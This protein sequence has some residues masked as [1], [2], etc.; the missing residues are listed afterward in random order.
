MDELQS[1]LT[2][3]LL[4]PF[5]LQ[6]L[7]RSSWFPV[8]TMETSKLNAIVASIIAVAGGV[9]IAFTYNAQSGVLTVT[10]LTLASIWNAL[11]HSILQF[12]MQHTVYRV[13]IAPPL[14]GPTQAAQREQPPKA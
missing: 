13:A 4:V 14:P 9:G 5:I 2:L 8:L 10:G 7:K 1:Q 11:Q 6:W 12:M 3:A